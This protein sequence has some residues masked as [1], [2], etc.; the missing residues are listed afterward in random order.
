M[1]F[2]LTLNEGVK[3]KKFTCEYQVSEVGHYPAPL[4][5]AVCVTDEVADIYAHR[6]VF[7]YSSLILDSGEV[8]CD[9]GNIRSLD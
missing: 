4:N 9:V 2:I 1:G 7:A 3:G 8:A 6:N 5:T